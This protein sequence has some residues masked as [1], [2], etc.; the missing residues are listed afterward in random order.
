MIITRTEMTTSSSINVKAKRD[1]TG[2][3]LAALPCIEPDIAS[4]ITEL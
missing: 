4:D 3:S 1:R 2:D